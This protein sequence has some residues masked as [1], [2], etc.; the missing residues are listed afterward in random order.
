V[1][2]VATEAGLLLSLRNIAQDDEQPATSF[3]LSQANGDGVAKTPM[4]AMMQ[5]SEH[6]GAK[7]FLSDKDA[8]VATSR[9]LR[10]T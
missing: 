2:P 5:C 8:E 3:D 7:P 9:Q 10:L 6:C 4:P 1:Q